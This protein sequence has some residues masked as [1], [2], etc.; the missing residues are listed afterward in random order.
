MQIH[1][2]KYEHR[3]PKLWYS[4]VSA[5]FPFFVFDTR[6][7]RQPDDPYKAN[8][9]ERNTII[10]DPRQW[11]DFETWLRKNSESDGPLF[12]ASGS[13][14]GPVRSAFSTFPSL[15]PHSDGLLGYPGFLSEVAKLLAQHE[16]SNRIIWLSGNPHLSSVNE[17]EFSY[18]N[19]KP[20]AKILNIT[21]SG[22][23]APL[24][25]INNHKGDYGW[26]NSNNK[27]LT[28]QS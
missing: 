5:G 21:A 7:G 28:R 23:F 19:E 6:T 16:L 17:L 8:R 11:D 20:I 1:S 13:P 25:F 24:P 3:K 26:M 12:I 22:L 4:F 9:Q 14:I 18:K 10:S 2:R 15:T 27:N